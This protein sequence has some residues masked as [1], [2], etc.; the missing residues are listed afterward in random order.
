MT[1][2]YRHLMRERAAIERDF[3]HYKVQW[4]KTKEDLYD[5]RDAGELSEGELDKQLGR[6]ELAYGQ[7]KLENID[8]KNAI[9][10]ALLDEI[11]AM[12]QSAAEAGRPAV[13]RPDG[14]IDFGKAFL[15][16]AD[17][18]QEISRKINTFDKVLIDTE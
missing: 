8:K 13:F 6:A 10:D 16:L 17:Q 15:F 3:V 7:V 12:N 1:E 5:R 14:K 4:L 11:E 18:V 9:E 2:K